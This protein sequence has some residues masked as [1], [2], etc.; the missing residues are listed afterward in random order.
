MQNAGYG[1]G[2]RWPGSLGIRG[3]YGAVYAPTISKSDY[4]AAN[5]DGFVE[6]VVAV[7]MAG[8]YFCSLFAAGSGIYLLRHVKDWA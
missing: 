7:V 6:A 1:V 8:T 5:Y 3:A 4:A 2:A